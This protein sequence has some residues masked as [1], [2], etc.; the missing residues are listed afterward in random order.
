MA[1]ISIPGVSDKYKTN[2]YIEALMQKERIPLTREQESLDRYKEQQS[3]WNAVNQKMSSLREST[4]TLYSFENPFN[5]KIASSSDEN[6]ITASAGRD[7]AFGSIKIDV[8]KP[9]SSDRFLSADLTKDTKVPAGKYTFQIG[10]KTISFDWKGGKVGDFV[11]SLNKRGN[12]FIKASLLGVSNGKQTLLIESLK[13]GFENAIEFKDDALSFALQNEIIQEK[14]INV[15]EF[16][17]D[18]KE[19]EQIPV[20]NEQEQDGFPPILPESVTS[21]TIDS[22][23]NNISVPP[24]T[25]FLIKLDPEI[26]GNENE[27]IEFTFFTEQTTDITEELN[28]KRMTRPALPEAGEVTFENIIIEN[29]LSETSLP[30]IPSEP[31]VPVTGKAEFYIL[32]KN[33]NETLIAADNFSETQNKGELSVSVDLKNFP[34]A[35]SL[36]VKNKNTGEIL[37]LSSFI[38]FDNK[39]NPGYFPVHPASEAGDAIIKYEGITI[40]RPTNTIDDVIPNVTL[41]I[42][43]QTEKTAIIKIEPDKEAAK[44][45]LIEFVGNYNQVMAE[46]NILSETKPEIISELTYLTDSEVETAEKRLGIFQGDFSLKNEKSSMQSIVSAIYRWSESA[47]ITMLN[48]IGISTRAAGGSGYS[49]GQLRGYLEINEKKLDELLDTNFDQIKNIFGYDSDG[50]L[51]IDSGIAYTLDKQ[52]SSWVQSGG[53][54]ANKNSTIAGRIQSS[55]SNIKKLETQLDA[56]EASL[57]QKYGQMEGTLNSLN[58]QS[59]TISNFLNSGKQ[60]Q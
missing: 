26:S 14:K 57:R 4:K 56:K 7:A 34:D 47:E 1:D 8:M 35:E 20:A 50:D 37:K 19:F 48:Q 11:T 5:N 32:D 6:A 44:N 2:D 53:I 41:N 55:E 52:L 33:G 36:L 12:N 45:A 59:S 51:I 54:I 42:L 38:A 16:G 58:S 27:S 28:I 49:P 17:I 18:I 3:A 22:E 13:T 23:T 43:N 40:N 46:I 24:R 21:V 9:A 39:E 29:N 31:L 15:N 30:P 25:A 60:Q 10:D